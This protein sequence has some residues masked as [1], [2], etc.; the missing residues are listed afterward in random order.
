MN[1]SILKNK[2]YGSL[3]GVVIGD[4]LGLPLETM[5]P[6]EIKSDLGYVN[7]YI[8]N[9]N[10]RF[11][12]IRKSHPGTTSDDS[13]LTLAMAWALSKRYDIETIKKAHV[14]AI[15]GKWGK[16]LGWGNTTRTAAENIKNKISPSVVKDGA[17]NGS[18]MK[19]SPLGIYATYRA[20][21][22][23]AG[24]YVD[25]YEASMIDKCHEVTSLTHGNPMCSVA[26]FC[27]ARMVIR[28]MQNEIPHSPQDIRTLF[29]S[30][31]SKA[32]KQLSQHVVFPEEILSERMEDILNDSMLEVHTAEVSKIICTSQSSFVYNSYPLVAYCI[33]KYF[34]YKNPFYAI[35]ETA[36]AGADADSN[37]SMVG[38]IMGAAFGYK[39][40]PLN[41]VKE[42]KNLNKISSTIKEFE[43]AN[44][45][46][47]G[48]TL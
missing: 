39:S 6:D 48:E 20:R 41:I 8:N 5:S 27:Q 17:G 35:T 12:S 19:I 4:A 13:Q 22:T 2:T 28:A 33:C 10:H 18:P 14:K 32:E 11:E 31:A 38:A 7:T 40:L 23:P 25:A 16:P 36:N 1:D 21:R 34:G 30:D 9:P 15:E 46:Y 3:M 47:V 43:Q 29:I 45:K 44:R 24:I 42:T 26:A 37:A